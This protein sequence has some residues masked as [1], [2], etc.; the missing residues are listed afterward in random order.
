MDLESSKDAT[1]FILMEMPGVNFSNILRLAFTREDPKSA[2]RHWWLFV[3][4]SDVF[5][6][7]LDLLA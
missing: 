5:L 7:F 6:H 3:F 1:E 4:L 2:E